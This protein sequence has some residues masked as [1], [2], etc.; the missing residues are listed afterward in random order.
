MN[1]WGVIG[2]IISLV[3]L[4]TAIVTPIV[5]LNATVVKLATVVDGLSKEVVTL[6]GNSRTTHDKLFNKIEEVSS[7]TSEH[8]TRITV[9]ENK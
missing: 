8:E 3:G 1:E 7:K 4:V 5:K 2:V 9:L 6:L